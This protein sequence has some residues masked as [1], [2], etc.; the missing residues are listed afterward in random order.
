M[1][2][3]ESYDFEVLHT[4]P[5]AVTLIL[6]YQRYRWQRK[7]IVLLLLEDYDENAGNIHLASA[8]LMMRLGRGGIRRR[9]RMYGF[10]V[11]LS[12]NV[13]CDRDSKSCVSVSDRQ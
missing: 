1:S 9:L 10:K 2:T 11:L 4:I 13:A 5:G 8:K 3:V 6:H 7:E 12:S